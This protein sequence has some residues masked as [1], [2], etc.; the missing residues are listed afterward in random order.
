VFVSL[1]GSAVA[2]K[3][4][5]HLSITFLSDRLPPPARKVTASVVALLG[6][7][8]FGIVAY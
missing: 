4:G 2:F 6:I 5:S 1:L 8:F 7:G 3:R